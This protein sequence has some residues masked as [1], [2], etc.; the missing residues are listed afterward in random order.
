MN[1]CLALQLIAFSG[2][3]HFGTEEGSCDIYA[4]TFKAQVLM[5]VFFPW[6][7]HVLCSVTDFLSGLRQVVWRWIFKGLAHA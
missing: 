4:V 1:I 3:E 2:C 5:A 7:S 6:H